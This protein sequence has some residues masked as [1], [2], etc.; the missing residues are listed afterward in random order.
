MTDHDNQRST[1]EI[2]KDISQSRERLDT[3]LNEIEDRFSPQQLLNNSYEYLRHGGAN[4]FVANLGTSIKQNPLPFLLTTAGLGW[5]MLSQ[6]QPHQGQERQ[7]YASDADQRFYTGKPYSSN[8][9]G[10]HDSPGVP[11]HEGTDPNAGMHAY[12][13][14]PN[15]MTSG[16][17]QHGDGKGRISEMT[18]KAKE[19]AQHLGQ[20]AK[21]TAQ[22]LGDKAHDMGDNMRDSTSHFQ[23]GAQDS[24]HNM[25]QRTRQAESQISDFYQQHPLVVGALGFALGAA[26]GGIFPATKKEDEAMGEYRDRALHKVAETGQEQMDKAQ[27]AIHEK[28]ESI[29]E[30]SHQ[31]SE[32]KGNEAQGAD[33]VE[34]DSPTPA[35]GSFGSRSS[36]GANSPEKNSPE[37]SSTEKNSTEKNSLGINSPERNSPGLA[38]SST[39]TGNTPGAGINHKP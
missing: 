10:S 39:P 21:Q 22:Q 28:A 15:G 23:H 12:G 38:A 6:R 29:K 18:D 4:E 19:S 11:V 24:L 16:N 27:H 14:I 3:T 17:E 13:D 2:E 25:G 30:A 34:K 26:L 5:M 20:K 32:T 36:T 1:E 9:R 7:Q 33:A 8:A 35:A 37:K 31:D